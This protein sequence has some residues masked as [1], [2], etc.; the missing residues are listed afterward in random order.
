MPAD[1]KTAPESP[2][3]PPE[4]AGNAGTGKEVSQQERLARALRDNLKKR[5]AQQRQRQGGGG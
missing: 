5:K 2:R 3:K 4:S 1:R